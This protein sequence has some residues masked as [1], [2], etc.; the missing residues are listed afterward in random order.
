MTWS[1]SFGLLHCTIRNSNPAPVC[2]HTFTFRLKLESSRP[3]S[4]E[5]AMPMPSGPMKCNRIWS[6]RPLSNRWSGRHLSHRVSA[7]RQSAIEWKLPSISWIFG[8]SYTGALHELA[9]HSG[10]LVCICL[11]S[12]NSIWSPRIACEIHDANRGPSTDK[13]SLSLS[14]CL[15]AIKSAVKICILEF[16]FESFLIRSKFLIN[17]QSF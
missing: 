7:V 13:P 2:R 17:L 15:R 11:H 6:D 4:F 8:A 9:P 16:R 12:I 5:L 10:S 1:K 3:V 14:L